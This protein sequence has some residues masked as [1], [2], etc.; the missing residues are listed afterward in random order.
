MFIGG[1]LAGCDE[2]PCDPGY[3]CSYAQYSLQCTSC[4]EGQMS[5]DGMQCSACPAGEQTNSPQSG[6]VPCSG[7]TFST[8][9]RCLPCFGTAIDGNKQCQACPLNQVADPPEDGCRCETSYYNASAGPLLCF[10]RDELFDGR[11]TQAP[12]P[13]DPNLF[14]QECPSDCVDCTY[15][16]YAGKPILNQGYASPTAS[17]ADWFEQ[18]PRVVF[19]CPV[20]RDACLA[21]ALPMHNGSVTVQP[22][23]KACKA[24]YRGILCTMCADGYSL[25]SV[26]CDECEKLT[27]AS[28]VSLAVLLSVVIGGITHLSRSLQKI[29]GSKRLRLII[30]LIPELIGDFKVFIGLYQVLCSMGPTLEITCECSSVL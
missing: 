16:G 23:D 1:R 14:C 22:S 2:H 9:G 27:P 29:G 17:A 24:G 21:E 13:T 19:E 10:G 18:I 26:G 11:L 30:A 25:G 15:T 3:S 28:A 12:K 4:P 8:S 20:D 5:T 7:N 6:C